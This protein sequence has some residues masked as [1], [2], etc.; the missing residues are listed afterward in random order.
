V[1]NIQEFEST[2]K[3]TP[4]DRG[5][6]AF[7][8]EGRRVGAFYHQMG[9]DIGGGIKAA[10]DV[11]AQHQEFQEISHGTALGATL[12]ANLHQ[13]QEQA[14]KDGDPNDP[15]VAAKWRQEVMEPQLQ[16]FQDGFSTKAGKMWALQHTASL[17]QNLTEKGLADQATM[18]GHAAVANLNTTLNQSGATVYNDPTS[19]DLARGVYDQSVEALIKSSPNMSADTA[20][21]LRAHGVEG[22]AQITIAQVRGMIDRNP[23]AGLDA[24]TKGGGAIDQYLSQEQR[25]GL[26]RYG[27]TSIRM[28]TEAQKA[29]LAAERQKQEDAGKVQASTLRTAMIGPTGAPQVT[30]QVVQA[31]KQFA[32]QYGQYLPG[33]VSALGNAIEAANKAGIDRTYATTNPKVFDILA[34][35]VGKP[36]GTPGAITPEMVDTAYAKGQLSE[37]DYS[38]F[39]E[40][41]EHAG[42]DPNF[43]ETSHRVTEALASLK[44]SVGKT[45]AFGNLFAPEAAQNFYRLQSD[46]QN[47]IDNLRASGMSEQQIRADMLDPTG[48]H[49]IGNPATLSHYTITTKASAMQAAMRQR[50]LAAPPPGQAGAPGATPSLTPE[51]QQ[52]LATH[53]GK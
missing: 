19:G 24:V 50:M 48:K 21:A 10:G 36:V 1:P 11:V 9:Q 28:Q 6:Q 16:K 5:T 53:R 17:R 41:I 49:F 2:A 44:P 14:L 4:D 29:A 25:D 3:L 35:G 47:T 23:Q 26:Q 33:E 51:Q 30:P 42:K 39:H 12:M 34:S 22:K 40:M 13:S 38:K 7:A 45:D 46:T 52:W 20:A 31:Y 15:T 8:M 43:A 32:G 37:H 27:Q 18:A